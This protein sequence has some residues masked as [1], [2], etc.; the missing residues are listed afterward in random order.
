MTNDYILELGN[1]AQI[2]RE[3][4]V[5][6]HKD[7]YDY[8]CGG[9]ALGTF[10]WYL[11]YKKY[12]ETTEDALYDIR[13]DDSLDEDGLCDALA[14][15]YIEY[16]EWD[17]GLREIN[18]IDDIKEGEHLV[19]FR[20]ANYDFHYIRQLSDGTWAQK[21]GGSEITQWTD[22]EVFAPRWDC[23]HTYGGRVRLLAVPNQINFCEQ[24]GLDDG[25]DDDDE[26][27]DF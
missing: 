14:D 16:M 15:Y 24:S 12:D 5:A 20:A 7:R 6:L 9:F 17:L 26:V 2:V 18:N 10:N 21:M 8:N 23:W 11:P 4:P 1:G 27:Y 3:V 22:E 19:A 13:E 25:D